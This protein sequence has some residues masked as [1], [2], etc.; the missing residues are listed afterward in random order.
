MKP[1]YTGLSAVAVFSACAT[2]GASAMVG[3]T[4]TAGLAL[5]RAHALSAAPNFSGVHT[6]TVIT[7]SKAEKDV[8]AV[9]T[10]FQ[11]YG[12][13]V[14]MLSHTKNLLV[15]GSYSQALRAGHTSLQTLSVR[16]ETFTRATRQPSFPAA[17]AR[18]IA[19]TSITP[20]L[21]FHPMSVLSLPQPRTFPGPATT[22]YRPADI[23]AIYDINPVYSS[24]I[25][26]KG[27]N[28]AI[29]ACSDVTSSDV[30][31]FGR[32][33]RL[34]A[35]QLTKIYV[36]GSAGA[37]VDGEAILDAE[38]VYGTAPNA[39]I[40]E[41]LAPD[42][43]DSEIIDVFTQIA[44]DSSKYHFSGASFSYG[45][46][47]SNYAAAGLSTV[48]VDESAA[49]AQLTAAGVPLFVASGDSGSWNNE[50]QP[51]VSYP[52]S[53][54]NAI[55]VGGTTLIETSSNTRSSETGWSGSG[56]GVSTVFSAPVW[57][58]SLGGAASHVYKNVPDVSMLADP[59]TG[60][61]MYAPDAFGIAGEFPIGGTS[62]SAPT[63]NGIWALINGARAS[64]GLPNVTNVG[65]K[66][67][68]HGYD[69]I[70]VITGG[71]GVYNATYG[72]DNTTGLG[73][74]DV[75]KLVADARYTM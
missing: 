75:A 16:S 50:L 68:S 40:Y 22:G 7:Q 60:A 53:D 4:L 32:D 11:S 47:E 65:Q 43:T 1:F 73:V 34:P 6:F 42:C 19:G 57:Q 54:T 3:P 45:Q 69:C 56:G 71:N 74:P 62:V 14:R 24:G 51:D 17:I 59:Y 70:D 41:Y 13:S 28:V 9:A 66:I 10:Y 64:Y 12:M 39:K 27:V 37:A 49:I 46:N 25:S 52:A 72:Y 30:V 33:F 61:A 67:Y 8:A 26:G 18:L 15:S 23:A 55:A 58:Q 44:E 36:D 35:L 21:H 48:L 5:Q 31:Q 63:F 20:G 2:A 38:R 29:A